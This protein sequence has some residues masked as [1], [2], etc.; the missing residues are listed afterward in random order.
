[1]P[2]RCT[3]GVPCVS[4][5]TLL[6]ANQGTPSIGYRTHQKFPILH[7]TPWPGTLHCSFT[8]SWDTPKGLSAIVLPNWSGF[9]TM[10][11]REPSGHT[12]MYLGYSQL[13]N[14]FG[15]YASAMHT[16]SFTEDDR[17][18]MI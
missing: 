5:Q 10:N 12:G 6:R 2:L 15:D 4:V 11:L 9:P 17:N 8:L 16:D 14:W 3:E 1:M 18:E 7:W 13:P